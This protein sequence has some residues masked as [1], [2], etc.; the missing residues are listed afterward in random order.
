M[1][2]CWEFVVNRNPET[3]VIKVYGE[4]FALT[5]KVIEEYSTRHLGVRTFILFILKFSTLIL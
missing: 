3:L 5:K 2:E 4:S 1:D